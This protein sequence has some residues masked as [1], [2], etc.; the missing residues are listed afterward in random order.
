LERRYF[1][2]MAGAGLDS[3]AVELV[4]WQVKKRIGPLAYVWAGLKALRIAPCQMTASA[5]ERS[6]CG[7]L[8]LIGN[9][10]RYGGEFR[11]FPKADLHDGLIDVC[12]FPRVNWMTLMLCTPSLLLRGTAPASLVDYFQAASVTLSS[13]G[14]MPLQADG[15]LIG[16][17][18]ARFS[19][20]R[21]KLRVVVP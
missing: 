3:R 15:E 12:V 10:R 1:A 19:V 14:P 21:S 13:A 20:E 9:G 7:Q 6:S 2:Q 17:L 5:D 4:E 16:E 8:V 18:P 11:L